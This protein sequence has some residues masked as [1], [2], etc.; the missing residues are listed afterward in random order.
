MLSHPV[1]QRKSN[2][3][4]LL[5]IIYIFSFQKGD[6][7]LLPP[8]PAS[9]KP[10][11]PHQAIL[12][13]T[14]ASPPPKPTNQIINNKP[15]HQTTLQ[16]IEDSGIKSK[17]LPRGLPSDGSAFAS[18]QQPQTVDEAEEAN[19]EEL[20][21]EFL[22]LQLGT[23]GFQKSLRIASVR[24]KTT[25]ITGC[26]CGKWVDPPFCKMDTF[27]LRSLALSVPICRNFQSNGAKWRSL[28]LWLLQ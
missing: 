23:V 22:R 3:Y 17:S 13:P 11:V 10:R 4:I 6:F 19:I 26:V 12:Q 2:Q 15:S 16:V 28:K 20:Q 18:F 21:L 14:P 25:L 24:S 5:R 7:P 9:N 8:P 1:Q 27:F